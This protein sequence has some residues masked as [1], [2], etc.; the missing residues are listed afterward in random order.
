[1]L[2]STGLSYIYYIDIGKLSTMKTRSSKKRS[3]SP[4]NV[5]AR[6]YLCV[7]I[8]ASDGSSTNASERGV[9]RF[10]NS[11]LSQPS[12]K[13]PSMS[14]STVAGTQLLPSSRSLDKRKLGRTRSDVEDLYRGVLHSKS[15]HRLFPC[16]ILSSRIQLIC[17]EGSSKAI[18]YL[19][20]EDGHWTPIDRG[21][22]AKSGYVSLPARRYSN[23]G[24]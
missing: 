8:R 11:T 21:R 18:L 23:D 10:L 2:A 12:L 9:L 5:C 16:Q 4:K 17:E 13:D 14:V 1:M 3:S 19:T 20:I 6:R 24:C 22:A 7:D 15:G